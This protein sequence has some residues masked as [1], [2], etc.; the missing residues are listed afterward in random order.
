[1][2][3]ICAKVVSSL[4]TH[5]NGEGSLSGVLTSKY[6]P[7]VSNLFFANDSLLFCKTSLAQWQ[8]LTQ[9]LKIYEEASGQR[10]NNNKMALFFSKNT[11][12]IERDAI[13]AVVG[14]P[15]T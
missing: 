10:L 11:T 6:G 4:L 13:V 9:L 15:M 3:L 12:T 8:A 1:L 14:I 2:F 7:R 5:A